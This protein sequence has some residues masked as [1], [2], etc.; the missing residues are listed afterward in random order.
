MA[1]LRWITS[2]ASVHSGVRRSTPLAG[3]VLAIALMGA[4][5]GLACSFHGYKPERTLVDRLLEGSRVVL[6]RPVSDNPFEYEIVRTLKG[7]GKP[8]P[9][10]FL[11]DSVKRRRLA[12]E[13]DDTVLLVLDDV[14]EWRMLAYVDS[15]LRPVLNSLLANLPDMAANGPARFE[16]FGGL[17]GHPGDDIADLAIR[18]LDMAPYAVLRE[19]RPAVSAQRLLDGLWV[20][21]NYPYQPIMVLLLGLSGSEEA[22]A[23]VHDFIDR[24]AD[25]TW[26]NNLGAFATALIELDGVAGVEKLER[27]FLR[28]RSQPLD[29]I[30]QI[31]AAYAVHNAINS[32]AVGDRISLSLRRFLKARPEGSA[33]IARQFQMRNDWS[34]ADLLQTKSGGRGR[35]GWADLVAVAGYLKQARAAALQ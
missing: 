20:P 3:A 22:R 8:V 16:F 6:A 35:A 29:K 14:G 18:E 7:E 2:L 17:L 31:V 13:Q 32:K 1:F 23:E 24:V 26:A 21:D 10:P 30:E 34:Q 9:I 5:T 15:T 4:G 19:L 12:K 11:V 27:T 28:D 25:W 33:A